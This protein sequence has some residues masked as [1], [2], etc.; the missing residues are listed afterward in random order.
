MY[1]VTT[2]TPAL[3]QQLVTVWEAS[4]R[5]THLFL[6]DAEIMQIKAY[7]P[8]ALREVAHLI[9]MEN[10]PGQ[11]VAL[12]GVAGHRLEMLFIAPEARG[13]GLGRALLT[14][15]VQRYGVNELTVN[16]QNPQAVGFYQHMGFETYRRTALDEQGQP[17]PLLYMRRTY[18]D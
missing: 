18:S 12:M 5:A 14:G 3:V 9:V 10:E 1:E 8:Q 11:P 6:S 7:V 17:Y 15:G 13:A 2:R 16:E 4:V